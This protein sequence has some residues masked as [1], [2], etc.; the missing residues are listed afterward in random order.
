ML[1]TRRVL[2]EFGLAGLG[3]AAFGPPVAAQGTA[4]GPGQPVAKFPVA[5]PAAAEAVPFL[6]IETGAHVA[7]TSD[8]AI[9]AAGRL[10]VTASDDK[11]ARLWSLPELRPLGV[12]RPPLGPER[13]GAIYGVAVTPDGRL[14]ALGGWFGANARGGVLLFDLVTRQVV[15]HFTE[16]SSSVTRL[17]ISA[18]GLRLAAGTG[19]TGGVVLWR[20]AD[21]ALLRRDSDY[22]GA[23]NGLAFAANGRLAASAADGALRLYDAAG[24][25]MQKV[26][27]TAGRAPSGLAFTPNATRLAVAFW[28]VLA[29]EVRDAATLAVLGQPSLDG[30]G[31]G[32]T[33]TTAVG[34]SADGAT[35]FAGVRSDAPNPPPLRPVYAWGAQGTGPRREAARGFGNAVGGLAVLPGG[36]VAYHSY[37]GDIAVAD[38]QG[39][40]GVERLGGAGVLRRESGVNPSQRLPLSPDGRSVAWVFQPTQQRWQRFDAASAELMLG[41]PPAAGMT[42]STDRGPGLVLTDWAAGLE[43]KL[44][45]KV[46]QLGLGGGQ[47]V[48]A[49]SVLGGRALIG[50]AWSLFL[51]GADGVKLWER[52]ILAQVLR[53]NLSA[54][55]RLAVAAHSDGTIRWRRA[56]DGAEVLAL[57]VTPDATR[58]V[59]WTPSSYYAA[60]PGGEDLIGWHVNRG[61]DKAGDFFPGSRFRDRFYRP[62]VVKLA[63]TALDEAKALDQANATRRQATRDLPPAGTPLASTLTAD[64]PAIATILAPAEDAE[65]AGGI[66]TISISLRSPSGAAVSQ[67]VP[68]LD[69]SPA[70]GVS[71]LQSIATPHVAATHGEQYFSFTLP[72]PPGRASLLAVRADTATREGLVATRRLRAV[73]AGGAAGQATAGA[74]GQATG[75]PA[76][77]AVA[78]PAATLPRLNALL[79][80]VADYANPSYRNGVGFAAKDAGDLAELLRGQAQRSLFRDRVKVQTLTN[81]QA[82]RGA[83]LDGLQALR[84]AT[85][86]DDVTVVSFAGHGVLD[87]GATHFMPQD[88]DVERLASTAVDPGQLG[89]LIAGLH[90]RVLVLFDICHA[91]NAMFAA[92]RTPDMSGLVNQMRKPGAGVMV[93]AATPASESAIE[94]PGGQNGA[95]TDAVLRALR[96][97]AQ[98]DAEGLVYTDQLIAYSK[99]WMRQA[100][101]RNPISYPLDPNLPDFPLLALR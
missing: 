1:V 101:K 34:W 19:G 97:G 57:F 67:V 81:A 43:P 61:S 9:D 99:Q 64:L 7:R 28:D 80:G 76:A 25:R 36:G 73:A 45:G 58:W 47:R 20:L 2:A 79:I 30:L 50:T 29:L 3:L 87:D 52:P 56:A 48:Q 39:R 92:N 13:E 26:V 66:A 89:G 42:D 8:C 60:S 23:V 95:F 78:D 16:V 94:V 24:E 54:D 72:L 69:G 62:D 10:L 32:L 41:E 96:G 11:T 40:Q 100:Y 5:A 53:C 31:G 85:R 15:R 98:A 91:G 35:L 84:A 59:A 51:F 55:G 6:Q 37:S 74:A 44:N 33:G 65:I 86:P 22:A 70:V 27:T 75:G 49:V 88:G 93:L 12:L 82:T 83:V 68:L 18:D 38:A 90:G 17:A 14:A 21:G 71:A 4:Q 77:P 46:L 63:L